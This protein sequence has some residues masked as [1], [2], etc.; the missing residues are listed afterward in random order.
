MS[1]KSKS[2]LYLLQRQWKYDGKNCQPSFPRRSLR[3]KVKLKFFSPRWILGFQQ[4]EFYTSGSPVWVGPQK[5]MPDILNCYF[6]NSLSLL[7]MLCTRK[8]SRNGDNK[9]VSNLFDIVGD[10]VRSTIFFWFTYFLCRIPLSKF[11]ADDSGCWL[12]APESQLCV[13]DDR[14]YAADYLPGDGWWVA[15]SGLRL[16][17]VESQLR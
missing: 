14:N 16:V 17:E 4:S 5:L 7:K 9:I 2:C 10:P 1:H 6:K 8:L 3:N 15:T 11:P 13:R 12:A